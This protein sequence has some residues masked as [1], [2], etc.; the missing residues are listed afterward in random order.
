M[1]RPVSCINLFNA[2]IPKVTLGSSEGRVIQQLSRASLSL[3]LSERPSSPL[4]RILGQEAPVRLERLRALA[5]ITFTL[6]RDSTI[7]RKFKFK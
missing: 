2:S 3:S 7:D 5:F 6:F 1:Y 4:F